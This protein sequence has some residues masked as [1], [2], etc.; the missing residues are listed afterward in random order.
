MT[1][2]RWPLLTPI[3]LGVIAIASGPLPGLPGQ[4]ALWP[5]LGVFPGMPLALLLGWRRSAQVRGVLGVAL[6]PLVAALLGWLL[7]RAGVGLARAAL[8]IGVGSWL[9]WITLEF[10]RM[11]R[12]PAAAVDDP[13]EPAPVRILGW[14]LA[15]AVALPLLFNA[16]LRVH[17]DGWVHA[18]LVWEIVRRGFPPQDP[19]FAGQPLSYVWFYHLYL[20]LL[21]SLRGQDPLTFMAIQNVV[22]VAWIARVAFRLGFAVWRDRD[23]ASG[24]ALLLAIGFNALVWLL[25]PLRLLT[26]LTGEVRGMEDVRRVLHDSYLF[27][28]RVFFTLSAPYAHTVSFLDKFLLGT[29]LTYAWLLVLVYLWAL[30]EWTLEARREALV[31]GVLCPAGI[32]LFHFVPG[33]AVPPA[34][35]GALLIAALLRRHW[36]WLPE[37]GRLAAFAIA[38]VIGLALV[39]PYTIS[40]LRGWNPGSTGLREPLVRIRYVTPWTLLTSCA[41]ALAFAWR[42]LARLWRERRAPGVLIAFAMLL[43]TALALV[44][45]LTEDNESKLVILCFFPLAVIGGAA[46]LPWFR[47]VRRRSVP[48]FALTIALLVAHEVMM[49]VGYAADPRGKTAAELDASPAVVDLYRW[50]RDST[51]TRAVFVDNRFR[52]LI[53]VRGQRRLYYGSTFGPERAGFPIAQVTERRKVMNDLYAVYPDLD[54]RSP[55]DLA[56][57]STALRRVGAPVYVLYR[58]EDFSGAQPWRYLEYKRETF[59]PVY[60]RDGYRVFAL[61]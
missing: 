20:A 53:M 17:G 19:R 58:E 23:A 9:A 41:V 26:A 52:D 8:V 44:I 34:V 25:W 30:A 10:L 3:A 21:T 18:G 48:L 35:I 2:T 45:H 32:M 42:P 28:D 37:T 56:R 61:R 33:L 39:M 51:E 11:R 36:P 57:D 15:I 49:L 54:L 4:V 13:D 40:I 5:A 50:M 46:V 38:S 60:S 1:R 31:L 16:W 12:V 47:A 27:D 7:G 24:S 29:P 6:A 59:V 22:L 43:V 14:T 55:S